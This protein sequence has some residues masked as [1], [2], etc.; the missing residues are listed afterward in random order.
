VALD[1]RIL[2]KI[3]FCKTIMNTTKLKM[4]AKTKNVKK[5]AAKIQNSKCHKSDIFDLNSEKMI[6]EKKD[7]ILNLHKTYSLQ[8]QRAWKPHKIKKYCQKQRCCQH[9]IEETKAIQRRKE[10]KRKPKNKMETIFKFC[11][12]V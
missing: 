2:I 6:V 4:V 7:R 5:M 11:R 9:K 10:T 8:T 1:L 3:I 12:Y